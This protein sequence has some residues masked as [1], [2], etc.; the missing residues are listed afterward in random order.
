MSRIANR[1]AALAGLTAIVG[2][3]L[4]VHHYLRRT[5]ETT[6][7]SETP[8]PAPAPQEDPIDTFPY[9][10]RKDATVFS[11]LRE[12]RVTPSVIHTLVTIAKPT[13]DLARVRPGTRFQ[14]YYD[15]TNPETLTGMKVRLS[16]VEVLELH[17][18]LGENDWTAAMT[19]EN[20]QN[21]I[22]AYTGLVTSSLWESAS[23]AEIDPVLIAELTEIFGWQVDFAREVRTNDRWRLLVEQNVVRGRAI[24]WGRI[25]AA[26]Y[27]NAGTVYTAVL[28]RREGQ[29]V[30][31]FSPD[32]SSLRRMFLKAP[33]P[34]ARISSRFQNRRFHPILKINRP[35]LGVDYA[36]APGTPARTVGD[37]TVTFVG[38]KG[39]AGKVIQ[40]RHN[41][42]Y[43]TAYKHLS[44][45]AKGLH[46]GSRVRQG[47]VIGYVGSTGLSTGPHLHFEFYEN[48]RF[49]DPLGRK[50]PSADPVPAAQLA[51]HHQ[52][53]QRVLPL[54]PAWFA[55]GITKPGPVSVA[56]SLDPAKAPSKLAQ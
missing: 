47:Q 32:G 55:P 48:G 23:G 16:P 54:L 30:G 56:S 36:A 29:D 5:Q 49:V 26:E 4:G 51:E 38:W 35:H 52:Q 27:D 34:M 40:I 18:G 7:V 11:A 39:G 33:I 43:A 19:R 28:Y 1:L 45:Y 12:L 50:F 37:G 31:Y 17:R 20:V 8:P 9:E 10:I 21:R 24:G 13:F 44:G 42:T 6:D 22:L 15:P 25:L 2:G 14:L 46:A 53:V 3:S 41:S